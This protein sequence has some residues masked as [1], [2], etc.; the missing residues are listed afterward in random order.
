MNV[1]V[2]VEEM[3]RGQ[4]HDEIET[5]QDQEQQL[6]LLIHLYLIF[7]QLSMKMVVVEVAVEEE[8]KNQDH[9]MLYLMMEVHDQKVHY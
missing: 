4:Y 3:M 7:D 9:Q 1:G 2:M 6:R 8:I 5:N